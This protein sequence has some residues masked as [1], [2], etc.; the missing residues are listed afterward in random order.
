MNNTKWEA[1]CLGSEGYIVKPDN[2][3][4]SATKVREELKERL[5][6]IA[7][8]HGSFEKQ[9]ANAHLIAAAPDLYEALLKYGSALMFLEGNFKERFSKTE[10]ESLQ[11]AYRKGT[12]A[13]AKAEG[14]VEK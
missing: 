3:G 2:R 8:L 9:K 14:K 13:L 5:T 4:L 12:E 10:L 11:Q 7:T 1:Y 6:P